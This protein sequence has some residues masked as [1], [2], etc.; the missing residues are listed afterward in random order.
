MRP[1]L[2]ER[3]DDYRLSFLQGNFVTLTN[4]NDNEIRRII[5]KRLSP[6]HVSLHAITPEVRKRLMGRNHTRGIEALERLLCA[7]IEA[8]AQLVLVPGIN[9]EEELDATLAW[10]EQR[11]NILSVG[12]V[13]YGYTDYARIRESFDAEKARRVIARVAPWQKRSREQSGATRFQLADEWYLLADVPLPP[14]EHYD[15]YPQFEDG[16]GMLRAFEDEWDRGRGDEWDKRG[17]KWGRFLCLAD[18]KTQEPSP[19]VSQEPSPFVSPFVSPTSAFVPSPSTAPHTTITLVTGEAFAPTLGRLVGCSFPSSVIEVLAVHNRFF[20]GNVNVAGL[21]TAQDIIVQLEER[22][23]PHESI[24][25]LPSVM[26]NADG[27]TLD[28][29]RAD[30]IAAALNRQVIVIPCTAEEVL[31][32]AGCLVEHH[33][34]HREG[35]RDRNRV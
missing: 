29:K 31:R 3:D 33:D 18:G 17:D 10:I 27:L 8:H 13:P 22:G 12:I 32:L 5:D 11:P 4:L 25:V 20:G 34:G 30:D 9:E 2:Y 19:F 21:L 14:A 7:G 1:S 16:I 6:L 28:D 15:G 23:L 26:F 24:V 35:H